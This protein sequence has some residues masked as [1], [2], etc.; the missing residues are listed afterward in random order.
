MDNDELEQRVIAFAEKYHYRAYR[1][2]NPPAEQA[3]AGAIFALRDEGFGDPRLQADYT[4]EDLI[5]E[6]TAFEETLSTD[7]E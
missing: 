6:F 5:A 7:D 2:V 3:E 1:L 4:A